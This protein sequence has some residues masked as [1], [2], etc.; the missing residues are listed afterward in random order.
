M[1][2][3]RGCSGSFT[4]LPEI[5]MVTSPPLLLAKIDFVKVPGLPWLLYSA[6]MTADFPGAMASRGHLGVVQ[7][8]LAETFD[9][10]SGSVPVFTNLKS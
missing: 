9:K 4:T 10:M 2:G 6:V 8:Q 5:V 7:P 1:M 3:E